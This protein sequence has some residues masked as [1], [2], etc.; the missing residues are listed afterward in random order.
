MPLL[1]RPRVFR[2]RPPRSREQA[3]AAAR[4]LA[5][6]DRRD[7]AGREGADG[8]ESAGAR[9][10]T[11]K[12][13]PTRPRARPST[14][15]R[16]DGYRALAGTEAIVPAMQSIEEFA[17]WPRKPGVCRAFA[18]GANGIRTRDLLRAKE[19]QPLRTVAS[20]RQTASSHGR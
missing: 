16:H 11:P 8:H 15:A 13:R 19:R 6:R 10:S 7:F 17:A 1:E 2:D 14:G 20:C 9:G 12:E 5:A 18:S 4:R 3:T